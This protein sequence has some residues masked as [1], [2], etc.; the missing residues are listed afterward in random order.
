MSR[1]PQS[2][3]TGVRVSTEEQRLDCKQAEPLKAA[4]KTVITSQNTRVLRQGL[5]TVRNET[6][7]SEGRCRVT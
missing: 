6:V 7:Q 3:R 1:K 5:V 4:D 2:R